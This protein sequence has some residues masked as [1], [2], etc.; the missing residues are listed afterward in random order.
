MLPTATSGPRSDAGARRGRDAA[1]RVGLA[2]RR[3]GLGAGGAAGDGAPRRPACGRRHDAGRLGRGGVGRAGCLGRRRAG[4]G[5]ARDSNRAKVRAGD[6]AGGDL[7][8]RSFY[9]R[10]P[11]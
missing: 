2:G 5:A 10:G 8:A 4:G 1:P 9:L 11:D 3:Q 7:G 6:G